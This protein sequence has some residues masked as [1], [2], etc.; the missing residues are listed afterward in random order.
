MRQTF[1][2]LKSRYVSGNTVVVSVAWGF[3]AR[4][5]QEKLGVPLATLHIEPYNIRSLYQSP[6]MPP[7]L[8]LYDWVPRIAKRLQFWIADR[9]VIDP[10]LAPATNAFRAELGLPSTRGLFAN[11]WHSPDLTIGL[12][13]P[14]FA[15]PQPDSP[16]QL[17]LTGFT[18]WDQDE[19]QQTPAEVLY[20][21][22]KLEIH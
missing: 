7:P 12:F 20:F 22:G 15:P 2:I 17:K 1:E 5:A 16:P 3:G 10:K 14:W 6:V 9:M 19:I 4:I 21:R 18:L 8:M 11:W 13:P